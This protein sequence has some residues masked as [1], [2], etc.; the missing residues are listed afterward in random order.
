M[1]TSDRPITAPIDRSKVLATSGMRNASASTAVTTPSL[2][3]SRHVVAVRN[4]S[5]ASVNTTMNRSHRYSGGGAAR[6]EQSSSGRCCDGASRR[7]VVLVPSGDLLGS[8]AH[9]GVVDLVDGQVVVAVQ[10]ADDAPVL[11]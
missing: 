1:M 8:V 3:T 9:L 7:S 6:A 5:L 10:G 4:W 2:N 11:Q